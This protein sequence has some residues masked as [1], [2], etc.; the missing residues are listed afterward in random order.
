MEPPKEYYAFISYKR[1]DEKWAK[2]LQKKLEGYKLPSVI[3]KERP[4]LPKYIRPIFRDSTDLSGGV[5][6][7]QLRQELLCSKF[8]I[9][10]CSP[11]AT[12]SDW[13]N[14]EAQTFIN[15]G[16]LEQIIP[17]VVAGTPHSDNAG[18][19][20]FP[21][22]L[23]DIPA[24]KELLGINVQDIGKDMAFIRLV[25]TMLG[26]RFDSLWQ[27]HRRNQFRRRVVYGCV[28][29]ILFLFGVFVWDY[30]R[31]TYE[32]YADW[33]DC[34]GVPE[35]I[36]PLTKEQVSHR[37]GSYQFEYSRIPF[38][39]PNA[40]SW[41]I[42]KVNYVNSALRPKEIDN[43]EMKDRYPVLEIE[44]NKQTGV[45]S[46]INFCNTKGSVLL[47]HILTER[48]GVTASVADFVDSKEQRGTGF[49]GASLSS[50]SLGEMDTEQRKSN[51]VRYVY[52]RD[53]RGHIILQTYHSSNDYQ[54]KRSAI[55]DNDGIWGR[56]FT[57]DSL[58]RRIKV[59]YLGVDG[60]PANTKKGFSAKVYEY[61][62]C[63]GFLKITYVNKNEK[64]VLNDN[65]WAIN[66]NVFDK[67][68]NEIERAYYDANG[69]SCYNKEGIAKEVLEYND[70]GL[71]IQLAY[72]DTE[73][74][75][76]LSKE[77]YAILKSEYDDK[78]NQIQYAFY[79]IDGQP[80]LSELGIFKVKLKYD[81][82]GNAI[83]FVFFDMNDNLTLSNY[84]PARGIAKY[85][86][87]GNQ[88]ECAF[89][90][91][92][93]QPYTI[94]EGY[95]KWI[96]KYDDRGYVTECNYFGADGQPCIME[97]GY[98]K[99]VYMYDDRGNVK[100]CAYYGTDGHPCLTDWGVA[101]WV[102]KYDDKGNEIER[103]FYGTDNHLCFNDEGNAVIEYKYDIYGNI[104][105]II[106]YDTQH[107]KCINKDGYFSMILG[108]DERGN[109]I[110][111]RYLGVNDEPVEIDGYYRSVSTY[112]EQSRLTNIVYYN[113]SNQECANQ[114]SS[115]II[116][117]AGSRA[118]KEGVPNQSVILQ[119]NEWKIG[120][121][122]DALSMEIGRSRYG[123]KDCYFLTPKGE[124][125][126]LYMERG[127][128]DI[129][130]R[131]YSID[132]ILAEKWLEKLEQYKKS[133]PNKH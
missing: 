72:Y 114:V 122:I 12:K 95:A 129:S 98:S 78:G 76:T 1:E 107:K 42:S 118:I 100:E 93:G 33:V 35:G 96:R 41:R 62:S 70:R 29:S 133:D 46:R 53:E 51:I 5:L 57:L 47:R 117:Q 80:C 61:G 126:H 19:E 116:I 94:N 128:F 127:Y 3:R 109:L 54:L 85:N 10:I 59:D 90:D 68:G 104:I 121:A 67:N 14:K 89:F 32:Y 88:L 132:K 30:N 43:S 99:W 6:V 91:A 16:R 79:G 81:N 87:R 37:S 27:R 73:G 84:G 38:G 11:N 17:F 64:P 71:P 31:S 69:K 13:M 108:Y 52:E 131:E 25:A 77:G 7:D 60:E 102:S 74:R 115:F 97:E 18:D 28:A 58:G 20:C 49:V 113:K 48:D 8:L 105:Q 112:D 124:I 44:Y 15:E 101:K 40:Y 56:R 130:L 34:Y 21:Q 111:R 26:V 63:G 119:Y 125:K 45:V 65:M 9:V 2:W 106:S 4:E 36:I 24:E 120:N 55:C 75:L 23:R 82:R 86:D 110:E 22:S 103:A 50:M 39:E 123:R 92:E 83:E 66:V